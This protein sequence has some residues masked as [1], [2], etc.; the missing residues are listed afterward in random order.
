MEPSFAKNVYNAF[1]FLVDDFG[2]G[3][4]ADGK[5]AHTFRGPHL[6]VVIA[7]SRCELNIIL[8]R[9]IYTS[10]LRPFKK[11]GFDLGW[12]LHYINPDELT[13]VRALKMT[14]KEPG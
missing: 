1:A 6:N 7:Y 5:Y 2:Y 12:L 3:Y 10:I 14:N 8:K 11:G 4:E 9:T 13:E